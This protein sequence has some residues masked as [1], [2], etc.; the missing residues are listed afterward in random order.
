MDGKTKTITIILI[1][2]LIF[3]PISSFFFQPPKPT[4]SILSIIIMYG[5]I[6]VAYGFIPKRIALSEDQILI[7]NLY[8]SILIDINNVTEVQA[9]RN[10][11]LNFRTFGVGGLF[12]YFGLFNGTDTWYV[13]NTQKQVKITLNK[14]KNYM[15]SPENPDEFISSLLKLRDKEAN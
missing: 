2:F 15:I 9:F 12:G 11:S 1:I 10:R 5:G 14:G 3:F 6:I 7:K 4:I 13:T 8:G